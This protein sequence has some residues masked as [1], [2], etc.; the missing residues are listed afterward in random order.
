ML[1]LNRDNKLVNFAKQVRGL[2]Y[3][4]LINPKRVK[5]LLIAMYDELIYVR[6]KHKKITNSDRIV[7]SKY[8]AQYQ[9]EED[10]IIG[11]LFELQQKTLDY[12]IS[13]AGVI[14]PNRLKK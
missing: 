4:K 3:S 7:N 11:L 8:I 6:D 2:N 1:D 10:I 9:A 12:A 5:R 14:K 13:L